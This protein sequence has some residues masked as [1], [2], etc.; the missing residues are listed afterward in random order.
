MTAQEWLQQVRETDEEIQILRR[1]MFDAWANVTRTTPV[2]TGV[3]VQHSADPHKYDAW[4]ELDEA[5]YDRIRELS[6]M[7]AQAVRIIAMLP[8]PRQRKVLTAYFV[9]SRDKD[10]RIKT[11]E[12]VAV[13]LSLS[14]RQLMY[15]RDAALRAVEKFC[16]RIAHPPCGSV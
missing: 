10:G 9:D 2:L 8:D 13:E 12:M 14:Y 15:S 11:W 4:A 6:A 7:K 16:D 3:A 5:V 1:S